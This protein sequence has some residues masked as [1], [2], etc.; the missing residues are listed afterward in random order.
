[1][2][3]KTTGICCTP[4]YA[5]YM[6]ELAK[7][8]GIDPKKDLY[9]KSIITGGEPGPASVPGLRDKLKEMWGAEIFDMY[10]APGTGLDYECECHKGFHI[11]C[12]S[13]LIQIVD[14]KTGE[15]LPYGEFGSIVGTSLGTAAF[16]WLRFN[17]EDQGSMTEELCE[18]GRTHPRILSVPG[19]WDDM[20]KIKG[21]QLHP[22]SIEKVV[23][24]TK[25][26]TGEFL[27][28]LEKD[29][30]LTDHVYIKVEYQPDVED[31]KRL[32]QYLEHASRVV[33]TLKAD[34]EM[35]PKGTLERYVMKKQRVIDNRT[36]DKKEKFDEATKLRSAKYFD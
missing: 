5:S 16:P 14:P 25:G 36:K 24:S 10:G 2:D 34:L 23:G 29:E 17:T 28:I 21:F 30:K 35:V 26:C 8:M 31:V 32:H 9:I 3:V 18:C 4:S 7:K 1:M 20:I 13:T 19:R 33:I 27:I 22:N 11:Q 6:P 15:E 12:D